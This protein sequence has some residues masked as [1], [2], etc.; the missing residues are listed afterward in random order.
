MLRDPSTRA[1]Y[2]GLNGSTFA[3]DD[4]ADA[5]RAAAALFYRAFHD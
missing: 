1:T 5:S 3:M 2:I 4:Y